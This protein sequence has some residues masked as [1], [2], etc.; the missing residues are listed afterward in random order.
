MASSHALP[1]LSTLDL[2]EGDAVGAPAALEALMSETDKQHPRKRRLRVP[3]SED[4]PI[5]KRNQQ[6]SEL[7]RAKPPHIKAV[8]KL[9]RNVN[10][11]R[12]SQGANSSL[13]LHISIPFCALCAFWH[14]L[15]TFASFCEQAR[16]R[17]SG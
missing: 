7:Q 3:P 8:E 2:R 13:E 11:T 4:L 16:T 5:A 15:P 14:V 10:P 6:A 1:N 17:R 9:F 12:L